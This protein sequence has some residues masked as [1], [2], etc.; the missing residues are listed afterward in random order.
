MAWQDEA[1]KHVNT[2]VILVSIAFNSGT[3]YY[4]NNYIETATQGY[5][6]NILSLPEIR[7]SIGDVKRTY[8]RNQLSIIFNDSDYEFRGLEDTE[9]VGFTNRTVTIQVAFG[10]DSYANPLTIF[11]GYI[12][13]WMHL[14]NLQ[15]QFEV[16]QKS[17]NIENKYP[18]YRINLDDYPNADGTAL[19]WAPIPYGAIS[20]LGLSGN[21]A[22]G[23]PSLAKGTGLPMIDTTV[24]GEKHFVGRQTAAITVDR[25]Y[26]DGA[27]QT[28]GAGND[29]QV[30]TQVIDGQ[31]HTEI[32][33]EAGNNPTTASFITCDL[34]FG[35]RRPVEAIRH[36]MENF[37][38]YASGDF[39]AAS[40]T[41]AA[42]KE[43]DRI[44]DFAG[45]L[46]EPKTLRAIL[47][48]WRDE[49]ELDIYW[50][51]SGEV[52]FNYLT[53]L[54]PTSP[55]HYQAKTDILNSFESDPQVDKLLNKVEY[56]YNYNYAKTYFY[57]HDEY[58][59]TDSQTKYGATYSEFY[60]FKWIR[61]ASVA[62]NVASRKVIRRKDPIVLDSV[63][64]PL[65]TF[66]DD[67]TNSLEITHFE[68]LGSS[69][70]NQR[71]FQIR[72]TEYN[73]NRFTNYMLLE[74]MSNFMGKA[75][76]LGDDTVL[77]AAWTNA[78]GN[79]QDYCYMC[80]ST[81]GEFSDNIEGKRL[82]D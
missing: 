12:Y 78:S 61:S 36:F 52:C 15:Y 54:L 1:D 57:N 44:Y 63:L 62:N 49:F 42:G 32:A 24:D 66:S 46:W 35:S 8:E 77:P 40:Y 81:T 4:S 56:G 14:D 64:F 45:A 80:D 69:G 6:G 73:L 23:H 22:F 10:D 79:E 34:T 38:G 41:T 47:D 58:E 11:T 65:K 25:V 75:C 76:I 33:W 31:T 2:P 39:N 13:A 51:K 18:N 28:V 21:G 71:R 50:N 3:R 53:A 70:Y 16:E 17:V 48:I 67:L 30:S 20:A 9:T 37:C 27:L 7:S 55:N 72:E 74:D 59:N 26:K 5:K 60:G 29:Y 19:I 82:L 43:D 68:G